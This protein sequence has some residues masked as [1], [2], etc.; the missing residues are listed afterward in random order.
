VLA[1]SWALI[2]GGVA[3][4]A[5]LQPG[6]VV[7]LAGAVLLLIAYHAWDADARPDAR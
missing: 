6:F 4:L 3:F 1:N 2:T 5:T 7:L